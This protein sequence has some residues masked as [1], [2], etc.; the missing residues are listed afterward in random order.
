MA[1]E[2]PVM[3]EGSEVSMMMM[4]M[5]MSFWQGVKCSFL[6]DAFTSTNT[7]TYFLGLLFAFF[8]GASVEVFTYMRGSIYD[9]AASSSSIPVSSKLLIAFM[10]LLM[11]LS[12][13]WA[14]LLVMTFNVGVI[15]AVVLGQVI[16]NYICYALK[17]K[18]QEAKGSLPATK[19]FRYDPHA[20]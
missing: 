5:P 8:L 2:A 4:M 15:L 6:F 16:T 17:M 11:T 3:S 14:M 9:K 12:G 7:G 13:L 18:Q 1:H 10:Y 19:A 20:D